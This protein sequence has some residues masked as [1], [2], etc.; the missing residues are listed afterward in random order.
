MSHQ[1]T[2]DP[3]RPA[4][5]DRLKPEF[6]RTRDV[7][8]TR[9]LKRGTIYNLFAD[10]KI[11]GYLLRVKGQ[12]SGVRLWDLQ[13]IDDFIRSQQSGKSGGAA[14]PN[15]GPNYETNGASSNEQ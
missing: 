15:G 13:S 6:A 7:E 5:V 8:A 9:G 14:A 1:L 3:V 4:E 12:K 2:T 11:R 10:G